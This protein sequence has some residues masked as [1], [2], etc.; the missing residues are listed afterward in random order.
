MLTTK[1]INVE[2]KDSKWL[3]D[4]NDISDSYHTFWELYKHRI[5]NFMAV[6]KLSMEL[7]QVVSERR[8]RWFDCIKSKKHDDWSTWEWW[9][10]MQ[11]ETK[12]WQ[13]SY[14]LPEEYWD[15]CP[16]AEEKELANKWDKHTSDDVLD[17]LLKI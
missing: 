12:E 14:H 5:H 9:F 16:F 8:D 13:I 6:C 17:R 3:I 1:W 15:K 11:L 2:I 10:I 7:E 4:T